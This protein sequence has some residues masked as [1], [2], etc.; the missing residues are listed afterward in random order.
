M[1][2]LKLTDRVKEWADTKE[3]L[4]PAKDTNNNWVLPYA[5][6]NQTRYQ[7]AWDLC[8]VIEGEISQENV[9]KARVKERIDYGVDVIKTVVVKVG[10]LGYEQAQ[11]QAKN[12]AAR[13]VIKALKTVYTKAEL[14]AIYDLV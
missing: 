10:E 11:E 12:Y 4:N 14:A 2:L 3:T 6:T 8:E 13:E 9:Y 1:K 7:K 5:V